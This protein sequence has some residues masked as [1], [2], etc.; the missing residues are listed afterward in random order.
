MHHCLF[1]QE[2]LRAIFLKQQECFISKFF[3]TEVIN[4]I[5]FLFFVSIKVP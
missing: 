2:L 1:I 5:F 3:I 4:K